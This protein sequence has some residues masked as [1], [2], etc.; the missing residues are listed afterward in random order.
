[1]RW[2][3]DEVMN[4]FR[5]AI[6]G[7]RVVCVAVLAMAGCSLL[8]PRGVPE[9]FAPLQTQRIAEASETLG[10]LSSVDAVVTL[11]RDFLESVILT[12]LARALEDA[13]G[14][15]DIHVEFNAQL[16]TFRAGADAGEI[17]FRVDD[18]ALTWHPVIFEPG[19][20]GKAAD[21]GWIR[22]LT[23]RGFNRIEL[24]LLPL[25]VLE[26]G[27][28]V[29]GGV[30]AVTDLSTPLQGR[31]VLQGAAVLVNRDA[32][33]M[34]LDVD[35]L[36]GVT[37]CGASASAPVDVLNYG[38]ADGVATGVQQ[39]E[40]TGPD[41]A[42]PTPPGVHVNREWR[43]YQVDGGNGCLLRIASAPETGQPSPAEG[44]L[45]F[46]ALQQAFERRVAVVSPSADLDAPM[47]IEL[48][49][50]F[51]AAALQ[52]TL[53]DQVL[54]VETPASP[55]RDGTHR[56]TVSNLSTDALGCSMTACS[57]QRQCT[58]NHEQCPL[59]R[60]TRDCRSCQLRN[61]LNNRC[62]SEVE[63][64]ACVQ[65][66]EARNRR[67]EVERTQCI[68]IEVAA[69][70]ACVALREQETESCR[71]DREDR[72]AACRG[73]ITALERLAGVPG[74][75]G[76][77]LATGEVEG[78]LD[79]VFLGFSVDPQLSRLR[80]GIALG[81]DLA[82]K[83]DLQFTTDASLAGALPCTR[84]WTGDYAGYAELRR[85]ETHLVAGLEPRDDRLVAEWS[86]LV[87][88]IVLS[89]SP[90]KALFRSRPGMLSGCGVGMTIDWVG[91]T[92]AGPGSDFINGKDEVTV[93]PLPTRLTLLPAW[94]REGGRTYAGAPSIDESRVLFEMELE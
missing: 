42:I 53:A 72:L 80:Q 24:G 45:G 39:G 41:G 74:A 8:P 10:R 84:A 12:G 49:R 67:L 81:A 93:Q 86:G 44:P 25:A 15:P 73:K 77:V 6:V 56:A 76:E 20:I 31:T 92:L 58:V 18:E 29:S 89:P 27:V 94:A 61:P 9:A 22:Q 48:R 43:V 32:V 38:Y 65:A 75:R 30:N 50:E 2:L 68:E 88:P 87:R 5:T 71:A 33:R 70:D 69:R 64:A 52:A 36:P 19:S 23:D 54:A 62:L 66:R 78:T 17:Q 55:G 26:A 51:L 34:A 59:E 35:L 3:L 47:R 16:I 91:S 46:P 37:T 40:W 90:V 63:D 7:A 60:D 82:V 57:Q 14:D 11:R 28:R 1:M 21:P 13:P 79:V 85:E 4:G 83:G